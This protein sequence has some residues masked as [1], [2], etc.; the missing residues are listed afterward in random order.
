M[1]HLFV[2]FL[3]LCFLSITSCTQDDCVEILWYQDADNDGFGNLN[4][5]ASSCNQ[6]TGYVSDSSD[7]DDTDANINPE[8]T[9]I[10]DNGIDENCNPDDDCTVLNW[11]QDQDS[12]NFGNPDITL[13]QCDQPTGY[14]LDNTDCDDTNA[15][16][17]PDATEIF[18]NGIDENCNPDD[19]CTVLDWYQDQDNDNFGNPNVMLS[20]CDQPT[21]YV[22]D[23]TDC[24][25]TN[26]NI[27]PSATEIVGNGIDDNCNLSPVIMLT[28]PVNNSIIPQNTNIDFTTSV[29]DDDTI[30]HVEFYIN[31]TLIDTKYFAPFNFNWQFSNTDIGLNTIKVIAYDSY[32][33]TNSD[34][35]QIEITPSVA[36][37][38]GT[39]EFTVISYFFDAGDDYTSTTTS[40][41]TT[42]VRMFDPILD[43]AYQDKSCGGT[44]GGNCQDENQY[45]RITF[46][47]FELSGSEGDSYIK[48]TPTLQNDGSLMER[49]V[50]DFFETVPG[51]ANSTNHFVI[52]NYIDNNTITIEHRYRYSTLIGGIKNYTGVKQ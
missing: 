34:I 2:L 45:Q 4:I 38:L 7:C 3:T 13:S 6:P 46:E 50:S 42:E 11:Y 12:D 21:G 25:D 37:F 19:G 35:M 23:N 1:K 24:D 22:L 9:E 14:V 17:N 40:T 8:E 15:E 30:T 52:G 31:N 28:S 16:I 20:Q 49:D 41:F 48:Y 5:I 18:D 43:V 51:F 32:S 47:N 36:A 39:F 10:P 44:V 29:N 33:Q 26:D 27:N